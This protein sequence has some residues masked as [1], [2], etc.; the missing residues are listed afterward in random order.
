[1]RQISVSCYVNPI[2]RQK[3]DISNHVCIH[4][5]PKRTCIV[6]FN[7]VFSVIH[8]IFQFYILS[9]LIANSVILCKKV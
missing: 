8:K 4:E 5:L 7:F 6:T 2:N 3:T 1:M 9:L